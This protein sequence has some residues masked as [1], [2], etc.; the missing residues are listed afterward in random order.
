MKL[1]NLLLI[2]LLISCATPTPTYIVS[3]VDSYG[4]LNIKRDIPIHFVTNGLNLRQK[5]V[6][7]LCKKA[8][9]YNFLNV[10]DFCHDF[11][12]LNAIVKAGLAGSNKVTDTI[13]STTTSCGIS[14]SKAPRSDSATS[15]SRAPTRD[16]LL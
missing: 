8:A 12:C 10:V 11:H 9:V 16:S 14:W 15:D 3:S 7:S 4:E 1:C 13:S 6:I 5:H 2:L